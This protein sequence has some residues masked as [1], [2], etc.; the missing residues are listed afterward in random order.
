MV[1][2]ISILVLL[3]LQ[4]EVG[5]KSQRKFYRICQLFIGDTGLVRTRFYRRARYL[6]PLLKLIHQWRADHFL[7]DDTAIIDSFPLSLY[8]PIRNLKAKVFKEEADISYNPSKRMWFYGFKVHMLVTLSG[9]IVNYVVTP[10]S[11]HDSQVVEE[12]VENSRYPYALAVLGYSS[13]SL[14]QKL[15][16]SGY[17]LW[18]PLR[19]NMS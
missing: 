13:E 11:V 17:C 3:V 9:F 15:S 2:D 4:A 14:K 16:Q 19:Q 18:T 1:S 5:I 7:H 10:A 8:L 6:I 12:L